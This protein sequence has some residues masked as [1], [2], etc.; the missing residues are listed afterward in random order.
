MARIQS[1]AWAKIWKQFDDW[2]KA[3]EERGHFFGWGSQRRKI[4]ALVN[5]KLENNTNTRRR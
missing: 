5:K 3:G 2:F 4:T 1:L